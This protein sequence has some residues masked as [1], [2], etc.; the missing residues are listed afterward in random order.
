[1]TDDNTTLGQPDSPPVGPVIPEGLATKIGKYL[2][3]AL[4]VLAALAEAGVEFDPDTQKAIGAIVLVAGAV[5]GGRYW[6]A[7]RAFGRRP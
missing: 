6:Q 5:M 4:A 2:M 7:A 1:M 3:T